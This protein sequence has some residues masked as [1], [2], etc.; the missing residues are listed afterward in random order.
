[1]VD[2]DEVSSEENKSIVSITDI[3]PEQY[4]DACSDGETTY[5]SN[6]EN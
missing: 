1:M 6:F 5:D 2:I 3:I 4:F